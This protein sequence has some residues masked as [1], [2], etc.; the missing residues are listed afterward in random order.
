MP[1]LAHSNLTPA[2]K[3]GAQLNLFGGQDQRL[4]KWI[5]GFDTSSMTPLEALLE[6]DKLK[7]YV[8]GLK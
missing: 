5:R 8:D 1:R 3:E 6:L 2:H 4:I 7:R